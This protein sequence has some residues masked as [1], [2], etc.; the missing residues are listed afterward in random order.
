MSYQPDRNGAPR[1]GPRKIEA[2]AAVNDPFRPLKDAFGRFATGV[3]VAACADGRGGITAITINSFTS[4]SLDPPLVLWCIEKKASTFPAFAS[5]AS[6]SVS[7]LGDAQQAISERFARHEPQPLAP[8]EY[9]IWRTGAPILKERLAGFDCEI[10]DRHQSGDHVI[11]VA[12]VV[13]FDSF[14]GAPLLYFASRYAKG[15]QAE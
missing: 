1:G 12:R 8:H 11:L 14:A 2:D 13:Q 5:A 9:E 15:P 7:I 10:V 3:C 4:V 6:Y